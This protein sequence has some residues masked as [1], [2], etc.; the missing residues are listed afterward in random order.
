[1]ILLEWSATLTTIGEKKILKLEKKELLKNGDVLNT[2]S[3]SLA[4]IEWGDKSITRLGANSKVVI[5]ENFISEDLSKINISFELLKWK[6]WSNVISI[7]SWESYFRQ[8]I[9]GTTAAVRGTVFEANYDDEY[10]IVHKHALELTNNN[11]KVA[12][13]YP[14][15]IFSLKTFSLE[16]L[17][18][19]IDKNF[20]KIN[21][22]L[23]AEYIKKLREEFIASFYET[24]PFNVIKKFS[25]EQKI[26]NILSQENPK[27]QFELYIKNLPEEKKAQMLAT[28]NTFAQSINFENGEDSFLY[29]FKLN[30]RENL[31]ENSQ[32]EGLKW[33]LVR[34]SLYDLNDL[35]TLK[36]FDKESFGHIIGFLNQHKDYVEEWWSYAKILWDIF[37]FN[38]KDINLE[39][40]KSKISSLHQ[41]GQS[42][43]HSGLDKILDF[44]TK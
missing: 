36:K 1:M 11:G 15:Q 16:D 33:T 40:L 38:G 9:K 32:N 2:L 25:Q 30:T 44:Y 5:K 27:E 13:I 35:L 37:L 8:E 42:I 6:T 34:H 4:V 14:G 29:R 39:T 26:L 22:K 17:K 19:F 18:E 10:M 28:L 31:F 43:I 3:N 12:E 20:Q 7:F 41:E 23:D 24:N 21:E